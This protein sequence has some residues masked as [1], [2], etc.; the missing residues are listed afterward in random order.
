MGTIFLKGNIILIQQ[1]YNIDIIRV[2]LH[3]SELN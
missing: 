3:H 1:E 2:A